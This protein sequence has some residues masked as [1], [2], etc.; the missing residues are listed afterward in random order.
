MQDVRELVDRL[1]EERDT[2]TGGRWKPG[3]LKQALERHLQGERVVIVANREP[4]IHERTRDG[5]VEV[6]AS[7]RAAW[8]PRSSP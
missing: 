6:L 7:R 1:S 3:R 4:Y 5:R 2:E 8:S